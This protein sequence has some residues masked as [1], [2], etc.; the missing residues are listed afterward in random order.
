MFSASVVCVRVC[1]SC[2]RTRVC[3]VIYVC[4][5]VCVCMHIFVLHV[6]SVLCACV[7]IGSFNVKSRVTSWILMKL[8][9][10]VVPVMLLSLVQFL[11]PYTP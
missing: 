1:L 4:V 11:A 10:F 5:V 8:G 7:S 3:V 2:V 9:M 6:C